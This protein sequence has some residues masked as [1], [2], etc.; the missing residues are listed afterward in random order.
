MFTKFNYYWRLFAT[1]L[2]FTLFGLGG[3]AIGFLLFPLIHLFSSNRVR[4]QRR[5]QYVVHRSF[6]LF[7]WTMKI[8]G[9][10]TYK[11]EGVEFLEDD[12]SGIVVAN[13]PSLIDVVFIVAC[14]PNA[15]CIVKKAAWSNPF[16]MGVMWATGYVSNDIPERMLEECIDRVQGDEKLVIFPEGTRTVPGRPMKLMRGAASIIVRS[17]TPFIPI[18]ITNNPTTLTKAEKW[19]QIPSKRMHLRMDV[20]AAID[21]GPYIIEG[22]SLSLASRRM[23]KM[24]R[25]ILVEGVERHERAH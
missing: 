12:S 7:V 17:R 20:R 11:I 15:L 10:L 24:L 1:G 5:C 16:M 3:I 22:E 19:Y 6:K 25:E 21:P 14:I 4:A 23:N 8:A 13:H 9:V 18:T 2:C